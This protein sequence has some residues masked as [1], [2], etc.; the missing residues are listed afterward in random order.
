MSGGAEQSKGYDL[1]SPPLDQN[2]NVPQLLVPWVPENWDLSADLHTWQWG[3]VPQLPPLFLADGSGVAQQ[4]TI[5]R[6]CHDKYALYVCFECC[7]SDIWGAYTRRDE[8]IFDEEVVEV[9]IS[10]GP[11][12]K[13]NYYEFE[14][15][16]NGVLLDARVHNP[17]ELRRDLQVDCNWDCPDLRWQATRNDLMGHWWAALAIPW[18]SIGGAD[19]SGFIYR[20]NFFRIER[21]H[22]SEPEFSCWS[23]TFTAPA[24]FHKPSY[25]G[26]LDTG[27]RG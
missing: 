8:S 13:Q 3:A 18:S 1:P 24:D 27:I 9:F 22:C 17:T 21:T 4:Q 10:H 5:V 2:R 26:I 25:F 23:P 15:S 11:D 19:G 7:D 16:P 20:A 6:V 14:I 12:P